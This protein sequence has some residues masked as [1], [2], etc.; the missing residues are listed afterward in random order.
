[1]ATLKDV[2]KL[3]CVDVSTVSRALNNASYVH[4]DTKAKIFEAV[5]QLSYQPNLLAKGLRQGKR[6]TIGLVIPSLKLTIFGEIA[7]S[8][9]SEARKMG[10]GV[11]VCST[12]NNPA[13]EEECLSRLRNGFV[14]GIIIA[15]TGKNGRLLRDIQ[16]SGI[17]VVQLVRAQEPCFSSVV[18]D[19]FSSAYTSVQYLVT[20]GCRKIGLI[21]GNLDITPYRERCRGYQKATAEYGISQHIFNSQSFGCDHYADGYKGASTLLNGTPG[22]DAIITAVDMQG[23]GAL[24]A[25]KQNHISVPGQVK[26]ISLTGH[27][28]GGMLETSMTSVEMPSNDIGKKVAQIIVEEIEA[29]Q[30]EKPPVQHVVFK[31]FL[32]LRETT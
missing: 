29:S 22:L 11:M 12:E 5:K 30:K 13:Q 28:I 15:S 17:S 9:E 14:D 4:P 26:V 23:I 2:A 8:I 6:N 3:A 24:R 16:C 32:V 31:T 20:K 1:M 25:L 7:Q 27:S 19:Y 18:A 10:Y 21:N